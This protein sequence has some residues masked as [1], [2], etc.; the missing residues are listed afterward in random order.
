VGGGSFAEVAAFFREEREEAKADRAE[1]KADR[2]ALEAK[3]E[4][5][6]AKAAKERAE[7]EAKIAELKVELT[8]T[9]APEAISNE[10]IDALQARL[11]GLHATK[12]LADEELHALEDLVADYIELKASVADAITEHVIYF[13]PGHTFGVASK[14]H[15]LVRLSAGM[16]GDAAFARQARRKYL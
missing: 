16:S 2:A 11:E 9:L 13:S 12:L 10:Q 14:L 15:K 3:L 4:A 7:M 8:P 1:A 6:D 5:K